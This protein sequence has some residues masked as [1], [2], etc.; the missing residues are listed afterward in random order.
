MSKYHQIFKN[1]LKNIL[2][3]LKCLIMEDYCIL[4]WIDGYYFVIPPKPW[5]IKLGIL[6]KP[7]N[8]YIYFLF[9]VDV[10]CFDLLAH[11]SKAHVSFSDQNLSIVRCLGRRCCHQLFT[12]SST[13]HIF[14]IFSRTTGSIS[15]KL[16]T[17]HPW[18]KG[19]QVCSNEGPHPFPREDNYEI[20]KYIDKIKK[21]SSPEPL[22]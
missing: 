10:I 11:L 8:A 1:W 13:F 5:D 22:G 7:C 20:A 18:V 16:G 2:P 9:T 17:K 4:R 21:S 12:L 15:T 19:I 14:I 6:H 3:R